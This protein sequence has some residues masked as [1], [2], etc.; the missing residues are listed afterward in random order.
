MDQGPY[1]RTS[2]RTGET[3]QGG[4]GRCKRLASGMVGFDSHLAHNAFVAQ[5]SG[6]RAFNPFTESSNLSEGTHGLEA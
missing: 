4:H 3:L 5:R 1:K 6:Q 2:E